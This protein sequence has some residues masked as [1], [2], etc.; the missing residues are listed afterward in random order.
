[1]VQ[2]HM[3]AEPD[4]VRHP[5]AAEPFITPIFPTGVSISFVLATCRLPKL[6]LL[7][8][9]CFFPFEEKGCYLYSSF[10]GVASVH[11]QS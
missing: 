7:L 3:D 11:T 5:C 2:Q 9:F 1:M 8:P 6:P 10:L 4:Q